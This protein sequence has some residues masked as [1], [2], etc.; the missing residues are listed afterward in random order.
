MTALVEEWFLMIRAEGSVSGRWS[1]PGG[2]HDEPSPSSLSTATVGMKAGAVNAKPIPN[3]LIV[4]SD[5]ADGPLSTQSDAQIQRHERLREGAAKQGMKMLAPEEERER[6][7]A[8]SPQSE[9]YESLREEA[10]KQGMKMLEEERERNK[11]MNELL[12]SRVEDLEAELARTRC[13]LGK[14]V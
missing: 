7:K 11:E 8:L 10:A 13:R 12:K 2:P 3:V 9:R 5:P 1:G 14:K 4:Y 6:N